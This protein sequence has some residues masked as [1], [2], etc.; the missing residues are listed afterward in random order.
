MEKTK[1]DKKTQNSTH[2]KA[3]GDFKNDKKTQKMFTKEKNIYKIKAPICTNEKTIKNNA[4]IRLYFSFYVL[5]NVF[6]VINCNNPC[7]L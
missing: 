4:N 2:S 3:F 7:N 5:K 6:N 1:Y